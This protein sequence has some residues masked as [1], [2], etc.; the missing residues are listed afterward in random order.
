MIGRIRILR[1]G[2][3]A[4]PVDFLL[5][6]AR[7]PSRR[8]AL[9]R[10]AEAAIASCDVDRALA[11][12]RGAGRLGTRVLGGEGAMGFAGEV[13]WAGRDCQW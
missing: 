3:P 13:C 5:A 4:S 11:H 2:C 1:P 10:G 8:A 12:M 7:P 9:E 6:A